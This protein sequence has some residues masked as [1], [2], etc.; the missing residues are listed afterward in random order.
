MRR[1]TKATQGITAVE[2]V[3]GMIILILLLGGVVLTTKQG[4]SQFQRSVANSDI[5]MR[6]S[7][8]MARITRELIGAGAG[9]PV[10]PP[11]PPLGNSSLDFQLP[12]VWQDGAVVW[13]PVVRYAWERDP[14]ELDNGIDDNRNGLVDEGV[15]VR[16]SDP[17]Q[18]GEQRAVVA[19]GASEFLQGEVQN[20]VDDNGNGLL[21][22]RGL[23]FSFENGM[24]VVRLSL[25]RIGSDGDRMVRTLQGSVRM[26]N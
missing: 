1:G 6:S 18:I 23:S 2:V 9:R 8:M 21:D 16:T 12:G 15:I 7:R 5:D 26:R 20:G 3:I 10:A 13:G 14:T 4:S 17:G 19:R 25:E 24:L 11:A 22:E